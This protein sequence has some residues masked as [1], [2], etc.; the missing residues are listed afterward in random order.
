MKPRQCNRHSP[1]CGRFFLFSLL[2]AGILFSPANSYSQNYGATNVSG[3]PYLRLNEINATAARHFI[4]HFSSNGQEKWEMSEDCF[5]AIYSEAG[6]SIENKVY[7]TK[8]GHF[9]YSVRTYGEDQLNPLLKRV[10]LDKFEAYTI[11]SVLEISDLKSTS[12]FF[13]I[14]NSTN[15]KTVKYFDGRFE[16]T[17]TYQNGR[18]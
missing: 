18:I 2:V 12:Y 10:T 6:G 13:H 4:R 7:Y 16:V 17:E 1:F 8:N 9:M 14:A 5:I 11:K 15:F 3:V